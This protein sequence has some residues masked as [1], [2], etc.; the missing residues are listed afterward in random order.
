MP[1]VQDSAN[2]DTSRLSPVTNTTTPGPTSVIPEASASMSA[3]MHCAMPLM[4]STYDSLS[5]QFYGSRVP[6]TRLLPVQGAQ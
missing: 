2:I 6:Q 4:A 3:F 5:R 1:S